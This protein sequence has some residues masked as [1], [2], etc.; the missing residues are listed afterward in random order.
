[1]SIRALI[2]GLSL[3]LIL[4]NQAMSNQFQSVVPLRIPDNVGEV[5]GAH[6]WRS[7]PVLEVRGSIEYKPL[8][9]VLERVPDEY[10]DLTNAYRGEVVLFKGLL[11]ENKELRQLRGKNVP[12]IYPPVP[13]D[14]LNGLYDPKTKKA[15]VSNR[16]Q[17]QPEAKGSTPLHEYGH[18]VDDA[19]GHIF[20]GEKK[21][22]SNTIFFDEVYQ[23]YKN[24]LPPGL[25]N[26]HEF[27]AEMFS[28]FYFTTESRDTLKVIC[29]EAF[30]YFE[31]LERSVVFGVRSVKKR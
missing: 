14:S 5:H 28:R 20:F 2:T 7:H 13:Y 19:L 9:D 18:L 8:L 31:N 21:L 23:K 29:S 11:T 27:F 22:L 16:F 30:S 12:G 25:Y 1:M 17:S 4:N 10:Q 3:S 24:Q 15:F 26:R 6:T